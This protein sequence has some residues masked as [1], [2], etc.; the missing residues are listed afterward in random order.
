MMREAQ[1]LMQDPAFQAHMKKMTQTAQ[2]QQSIK[3]TKEI[4]K[5]PEKVKE[6]QKNMETRLAEGQKQ[7]Q[8]LE[9]KDQQEQGKEKAIEGEKVGDND[10]DEEDKK[11]SASSQE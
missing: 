2:F 3:R 5:D 11:P 10:G 1:K 4:M 9:E 6:M 8:E 7:L